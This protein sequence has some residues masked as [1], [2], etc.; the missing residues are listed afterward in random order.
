MASKSERDSQ[1][2]KSADQS[3]GREALPFEPQRKRGKD[4]TKEANSTV[5]NAKEKKTEQRIQKKAK[6]N[7]KS[8]A[9]E[10]ELSDSSTVSAKAQARVDEIRAANRRKAKAKKESTNSSGPDSDGQIPKDVSRRM[11]RRMAILSLSPIAVGVSLFF[12]SYYVQSR[13]ILTLAPVVTLLAT[14]G[15]FGLGVLGLTYGMLSASWDEEPGS[16]VGLDEFKLNFGRVME[17]RK[18]SKSS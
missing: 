2:G 1:N 8:S 13:G 9:K 5:K 7:A 18:A 15:C 3:L 17:A 12:I 14:M 16:L 10:D 6:K 11:V 4:A